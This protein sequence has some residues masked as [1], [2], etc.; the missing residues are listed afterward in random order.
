MVKRG[1]SLF[2]GHGHGVSQPGGP[3]YQTHTKE[4]SNGLEKQQTRNERRVGQCDAHTRL[5]LIQIHVTMQPIERTCHSFA[6]VSQRKGE[7]GKEKKRAIFH[8]QQYRTG[9]AQ[10]RYKKKPQ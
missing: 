10:K 8:M 7:K 3:H 4:T 9:L 1:K 2:G 5:M 6:Y